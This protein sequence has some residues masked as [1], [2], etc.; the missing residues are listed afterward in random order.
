MEYSLVSAM[1]RDE[2]PNILS[3]PVNEGKVT[4]LNPNEDLAEPLAWNMEIPNLFRFAY[5]V[6]VEDG[7]TCPEYY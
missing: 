1:S 3:V 2:P 4:I 6:K 7:K 5:F